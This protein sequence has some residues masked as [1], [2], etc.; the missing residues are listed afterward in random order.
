MA[1]STN[2]GPSK[3]FGAPLK[4]FALMQGRFTVDMIIRTIWLVFRLGVHSL[5]VFVLRALLFGVY[6]RAV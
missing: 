6:N 1:V 5:S 4:R 3:G 2:W